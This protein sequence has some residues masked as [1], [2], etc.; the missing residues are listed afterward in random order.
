MRGRPKGCFCVG[1]KIQI[2]GP[3]L[4]FSKPLQCRAISER[5]VLRLAAKQVIPETDQIFWGAR[6][7]EL[8]RHGGWYFAIDARFSQ[9]TMARI[10]CV[11][12]RAHMFLFVDVVCFAVVSGIDVVLFMLVYPFKRGFFCDDQS[13]KYPRVEKETISATAQA[14]IA[15][16]LPSLVVSKCI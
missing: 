11:L 6:F 2:R 8:R 9:L 3:C 7:I 10:A 5:A 16:I 13:I 1:K 14:V 15:L 4:W 12:S